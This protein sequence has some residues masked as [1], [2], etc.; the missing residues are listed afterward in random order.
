MSGARDLPRVAK[1][2][3]GMVGLPM[4]ARAAR[5]EA[6]YRATAYVIRQKPRVIVQPRLGASS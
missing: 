2:G 3:L 6:A 5:L 4:F 1:L